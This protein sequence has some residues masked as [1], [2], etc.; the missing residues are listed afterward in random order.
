[1]LFITNILHDLLQTIPGR[2][3]LSQRR[4]TFLWKIIPSMN[5]NGNSL[6]HKIAGKKEGRQKFRR[7]GI[8]KNRLKS[9]L[10]FLYLTKTNCKLLLTS[11][12][13]ITRL[14]E[15]LST[16]CP[17][18]R[19]LFWWV[20]A[21]WCMHQSLLDKILCTNSYFSNHMQI[22]EPCYLLNNYT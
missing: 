15:P 19:Y 9:S 6:A 3:F 10:H 22:W 7:P 20:K 16:V 14:D 4:K 12:A 11:A 17:F 18:L 5:I 8:H 2:L 1:M 21:K 13:T